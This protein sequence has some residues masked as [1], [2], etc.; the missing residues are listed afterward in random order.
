[1]PGPVYAPKRTVDT[2]VSRVDNLERSLEAANELIVEM[3]LL[4]VPVDR[5]GELFPVMRSEDSRGGSSA[6]RKLN[7]F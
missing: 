7:G 2:L 4:L 5:R 3:R 6:V 1:M